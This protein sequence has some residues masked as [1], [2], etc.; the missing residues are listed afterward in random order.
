MSLEAIAVALL[1]LSPADLESSAARH[2]SLEFERVGR[3]TPERDGALDQAARAIASAALVSSAAD[4]ADL[5]TITESLSHAGAHDPSPRVFVVRGEPAS[6]SLASFLSRRDFSDEPASHLGVGA[7]RAH[8][9]VAIVTLLSLRR[10]TLE[11]FPRVFSRTGTSQ[12]LCGRLADGLVQPEL[13]VTRPDGKVDKLLPESKDDRFCAAVPFSSAGRHTVEV[14]ARSSRGPEVVAL[15]FTQVGPA[16]PRGQAANQ[17]EPSSPEEARAEIVRRIVSLRHAHITPP[18]ASDEK[19][20]AVAQ[21]YADRMAKEGFFSH[22]SPDGADLRARLRAA[23]YPY[24]NAGEN[25]G[26]APGPLAA[27]FGIEHSPGH[28]KNLLDPAFTH[29]GV[30]IARRSDGQIIV[31]EV[32]ALPAQEGGDPLDEAYRALERRRAQKKLPPLSRSPV[33]E[34][35]ARSHAEKALSLD[36]PKSDLPGEE[37]HERVFRAL[38]V[39]SAA[40]DIYVADHPTLI[41]DSPHLYDPATSHVGIGAVQ[42]D[43][44]KFGR[45]RYWVVVIYAGKR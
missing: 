21:A 14:I 30:G 37:I 38:D 13:Y 45:G 12:R 18:V 39:A 10:A 24:R 43:S 44:S 20:E 19:L 36:E 17:L 26:L 29:V 8:N 9:R 31:V 3:S 1:L 41:G 15:F 28:R 11:P 27:H 34:K 32:L 2:V 35:L 42:G 7:A 6:E 23:G 40:V 16:A 4:A 5:I 22:V 33:L 25:L